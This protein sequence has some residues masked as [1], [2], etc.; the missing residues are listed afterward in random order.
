MANSSR[1][2]LNKLRRGANAYNHA[3]GAIVEEVVN[4]PV[5][6]NSKL[7][8]VQPGSYTPPF[9]AQFQTNIVSL[10]FSE[11]ADAYTI[12]ASGAIPAPLQ[13]PLPYFMFANIDYEAGYA[14]LKAEYP[15]AAG[16]WVYNNPVVMGVGFPF[17]AFGQWDATVLGLL[18]PGDVIFP[19]TAV[20][21]GTNY[22]A[23]VIVR[24]SDVPYS[25]L[26]AATESTAFD[27][28]LLRYTVNVGQEA[29]F[30][31]KIT[32]S[33]GTEFG[34]FTKNPL[35]PESFQN[36]EQDRPNITDID[37]A[38]SVDKYNGFS[39]LRDHGVNSFRLN[40][41]VKDVRRI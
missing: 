17:A 39:S 12:V 31:N 24:V 14:Q 9:K 22:M 32:L 34:S 29:Q 1:L 4:V 10:F 30:A 3:N 6:S 38:F 19:Y 35:N 16:T 13:L 37:F 40:I 15:L 20:S 2:L 21:G 27:I 36:P 26:L 18:R 11:A 23:L 28:N 7:V 5:V 25:S 33:R 8:N 41:F